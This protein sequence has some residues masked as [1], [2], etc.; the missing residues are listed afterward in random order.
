MSFA[1]AKNE[2]VFNKTL[3][4]SNNTLIPS[5]TQTIRKSPW[6]SRLLGRIPVF[7]WVR[8]KIG[9][10]ING[11]TY[12]LSDVELQEYKIA[13]ICEDRLEFKRRERLAEFKVAKYMAARHESFY[14]HK[15]ILA[16]PKGSQERKRGFLLFI[17]TSKEQHGHYYGTRGM[18]KQE[19]ETELK[20]MGISLAGQKI[21]LKE[22]TEETKQLQNSRLR[23]RATKTEVLRIASGDREMFQKLRKIVSGLE[24]SD[25][26]RRQENQVKRARQKARAL[27]IWEGH[28]TLRS[29]FH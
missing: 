14:W 4:A 23:N 20:D 26:I 2:T 24:I 5:I 21:G 27:Q 3:I 9:Q 11:P 10:F 12:G 18:W 7:K 28:D 22:S 16:F 29:Y 8:T 6:F 13:Q 15:Y 25:L 19:V 1:D 17:L